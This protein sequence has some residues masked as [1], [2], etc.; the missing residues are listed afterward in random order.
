VYVS[1]NGIFTSRLE[2]DLSLAAGWLS[3]NEGGKDFL[4]II[5]RDQCVRNRAKIKSHDAMTSWLY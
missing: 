2:P 5:I 4:E 1:V 3:W